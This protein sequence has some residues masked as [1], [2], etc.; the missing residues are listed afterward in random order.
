MVECMKH[1][2]RKI[3]ELNANQ[4]MYTAKIAGEVGE[5]CMQAY[6]D[7]KDDVGK[8]VGE[9][10]GRQAEVEKALADLKRIELGGGASR[11]EA[12]GAGSET[13]EALGP[14]AGVSVGSGSGGQ[15]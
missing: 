9:I 10:Q 2:L 4:A 1:A 6:E 11:P 3:P 14:D 7:H 8:D 5:R 15:E 13:G 12:S